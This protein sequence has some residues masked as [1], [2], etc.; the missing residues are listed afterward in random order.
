MMGWEDSKAALQSFRDDGIRG[1]S[2]LHPRS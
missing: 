1:E 2:G